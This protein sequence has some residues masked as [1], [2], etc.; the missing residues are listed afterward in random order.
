M[1]KW[2][3]SIPRAEKWQ[4]TIFFKL[5]AALRNEAIERADVRMYQRGV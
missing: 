2:W 4:R 1:L 5:P 3:L